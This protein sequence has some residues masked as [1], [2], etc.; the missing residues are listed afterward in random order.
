MEFNDRGGIVDFK[1]FIHLALKK[2]ISWNL[3]TMFFDEST[4]TLEKAKE[5]N[6]ILVEEL[7]N[8]QAQLDE[9]I[10][11]NKVENNVM[12]DQQESITV[13]LDD[14]NTDSDQNKD[15]NY[16]EMEKKVKRKFDCSICQNNF[17]SKFSLERHQKLHSKEI[18]I[19]ENCGDKLLNVSNEQ[20]T[21]NLNS[22]NLKRQIVQDD[23][24]YSVSATNERPIETVTQDETDD[25]DFSTVNDMI[26]EDYNE[27]KIS[28]TN[29]ENIDETK[30]VKSVD[31]K[32][33]ESI[34]EE[35]M[36][37]VSIPQSEPNDFFNLQNQQELDHDTEKFDD[38][39]K[40]GDSKTSNEIEQKACNNTNIENGANSKENKKCLKEIPYPCSACPKG[41]FQLSN[42]RCHMNKY[43]PGEPILHMNRNESFNRQK[44]IQCE[45]CSKGFLKLNNFRFHMEKNH[46]DQNGARLEIYEPAGNALKQ[47]YCGICGKSCKRKDN[48]LRHQLI[49][50]EKKLKCSLCAV[51]F[52]SSSLLESHE[53]KH[54]ILKDFKKEQCEICGKTI[55]DISLK[56]HLE[57]HSGNRKTFKCMFCDKEYVDPKTMK[58]HEFVHF[59]KK[60][61]HCTTCNKSF[62][63]M[64][65]LRGHKTTHNTEKTLGCKICG[66]MFRTQAKLRYHKRTIHASD[67]ESKTYECTTCSKKLSTAKT[68]RQHEKI[69]TGDR[70]LAC[71]FN[72]SKRFKDRSELNAHMEIHKDERHKCSYCE[73]SFSKK[74]V[75]DAHIKS[76]L[77]VKEFQCTE[78]EKSFL[79]NWMLNR[80]LK[81]HA[82]SLTNQ[83]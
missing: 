14:G 53:K 10:A 40:I 61:F 26:N 35:I 55:Y 9:L 23:S 11:H 50:T 70:K 47:F 63:W 33:Q 25:E 76:H 7:K 12:D 41:F 60:P 68:L 22:E 46:P 67:G 15:S 37:N 13:P 66:E 74:V 3:M 17:A 30:E 32:L 65:S 28:P 19:G 34:E 20:S 27:I 59:G 49:H 56:K 71:G 82:N 31:I 80:H 81:S 29:H 75:L 4:S 58:E 8:L 39:L 62:K 43:H 38:N 42:Y 45:L 72:C 21:T 2:N 5:L 64:S 48:L 24:S 83:K 69:H 73:K 51:T 44:P 1:Y 52:Y 54:L 57:T 79:R 16:I 6:K 78:C 18:F 36:K 77:G